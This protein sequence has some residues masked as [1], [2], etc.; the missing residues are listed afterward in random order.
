M[1]RRNAI[2]NGDT[3]KPKYSFVS[4]NTKIKLKN[5]NVIR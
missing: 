1:K 2:D 3:P 4:P 5:P